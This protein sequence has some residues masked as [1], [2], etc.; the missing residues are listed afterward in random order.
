MLPT[1]AVLTAALLANEPGPA[2]DPPP[3]PVET[4]PD[5]VETQP[6]PVETTPATTPAAAAHKDYNAP[7]RQGRSRLSLS[8]GLIAFGDS[9]SDF[10]IG[11]S[12]GYFIVDNL[13]LGV[14]VLMT[15]GEAPFTLRT[16][17]SLLYIVPIEAEAQPYFGA[18]Y[19]HWFITDSAFLDQDTIGG[20]LGIVVR[21]SGVFFQLGLVAEQTISECEDD[22]TAFY[23]ELG[24]SLLL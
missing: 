3:D 2:D 11:G 18:F 12:Y 19:R 24:F 6:D 1:L 10:A 20:R 14:D 7:W 16:G 8:G 22:C 5:P 23:P 17:P 15:F 9:G 21:T 13:E 4:E